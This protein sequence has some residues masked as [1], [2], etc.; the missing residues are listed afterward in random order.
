MAGAEPLIAG[1]YRFVRPIGAGGMGRVW[2]AAD[3][4][5]GRDVA[6]KEVV[7]PDHLAHGERE[8]VREWTFR[9]AR[10]A[11]RVAHPNV[12]R[13]YD[14]LDAED[15]PLI[16]MEHVPSRSL[17]QLIRE[18]GP[19]P[20]DRVAAIGLA[21][22][23]A[24]EAA[25]VAGVQHHDVKPSNVLIGDDGRV[26]LT[27]FGSA[28]TD[29]G[30]GLG[31][32]GPL[33][34]SPDYIAPERLT[35]GASTALADL[36]SLGAT[37]YH[38]VEGRPPYGRET[39]ASTLWAVTTI[40]PDPARHAGPL[41]P[42][43]IGLL[44]RD[45]RARMTSGEVARRLRR[46][47]GASATPDVPPRRVVGRAPVLPERPGAVRR[48]AHR[49]VAAL[50][51][52]A[53]VLTAF[54]AAAS[55]AERPAPP[56]AAPPS[57]APVAVSADTFVLPADFRWWQDRSGF[58]VALP[59]AWQRSRRAGDAVVFSGPGGRPT[60]RIG[61]WPAGGAD[62]VAALVA[63]EGRARL[64]AYRRS[65]IEALPR[66]ADAVWEYTFRDPRTGP[67]RGLHRVVTANGRV[68]LLA[69]RAPARSWPGQLPAPAVVLASFRGARQA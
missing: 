65:R 30:G 61:V 52:V 13:I 42:V 50:A 14:V 59:A 69:W 36:W 47:A 10:A 8:L 17:Q 31:A 28:A 32:G 22:L 55:A 7:I 2:L 37:L 49:P 25:R 23:A 68:Y 12:V 29:G 35:S 58:R 64:P 33:F 6:I 48:R 44:Q 67:V 63:E 41:G 15:R 27:D 18:S 26:V 39:T 11:A 62:P 56:V 38:A 53:A 34:G 1:R 57:A 21:V 3:E 24:L 51:A 20:A 46:L 19:L 5:L 9:E 54:V 40:A 66:P 43:L 16:V 45:P 60:L 4:M